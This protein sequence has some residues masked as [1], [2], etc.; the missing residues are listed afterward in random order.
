MS[1]YKNKEDRKEQPG[2]F[3]KVITW[4]HSSACKS[5]C[6]LLVGFILAFLLYCVFCAP[7]QYDLSVGSIA[8]ETISATKDVVDEVTTEERRQT[9]AAAVEPSYRFQEGIKEEV[10]SSLKDVFNELRTVQQYAMTLH[11]DQNESLTSFSDTE[12]DYAL[13]L[14]TSISLTRYQIT[15]L[16]NTDSEEFEEMVSLVSTAVENSLNNLIREGQLNQSI[17]TILQIVG[18]RLD[19]SLTQNIVPSVLRACL[20]PNMIIEQETTEI[21]REAARSSVEPVIYLQ[22]QNIVREGERVTKSQLEMLHS[23]G[24]LKDNTYD[25]SSYYGAFLIVLLAMLVFVF[26][27]HLQNRSILLNPRKIS[28]A[29]IVLLIGLGFSV[30]IHQFFNAYLTPAAFVPLLLTVLLGSEVGYASV[31]TNAV[32]LSGLA[33]TTNNTY[34]YEMILLLL[35]SLIGGVT[36]VHFLKGFA[37]RIRVL[38]VS[39]L[40]AMINAVVVF[41]VSQ[42]TSSDTFNPLDHVLWSIGGG[43]LSGILAISFQPIFETLF[44]LATP[45][46]LQELCN[47]NQSLLRR[48]LLEAPGTYH[49]SIIVANLA[50]AAAERIGANP[51]L[52]RAAAHYHDIGKLKRPMFFKENQQ[53]E[54]PHDKIDPYIS[55]A[56]LTSHTRYGY[57]MAMKEHMPQ[58]MMDIILQHHGDTPVMFFY[59]KALQLSNGTPVDINEFR[60]EGPRPQTRE[61]AIVMLADTIEAAVRSMPDP[62]PK[63]INQFIER[64]V[65]GKLEDGQLSEAPITLRDIDEICDAFSAVLMGVFH[66]R[67]EYPEVLHRVPASAPHPVSVQTAV[68]SNIPAV[69]TTSEI[70]EPESKKESTEKDNIS[71]KISEQSPPKADRSNSNDTDNA[72]D[73]REG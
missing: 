45:S 6:I 47:P 35:M 7:Q 14:V 31:I 8:H 71:E 49:H 1:V 12:I 24:L 19:V 10:L 22:G 64:L 21:A 54:N 27:I 38:L 58:E 13:K 32:L 40:A 73:S 37:A 26:S 11:E 69:S 3:K 18:Y 25:L 33:A 20:K 65:R 44:R 72:I 61:A 46:R 59:H 55:A 4:F 62:T 28:V 56:I 23:L 36:S 9:A 42:M 16:L 68:P 5:A 53:V 39:L 15:T 67:I 30:I 70:Q 57:Q 50:E 17:Q 51:Y 66:E 60:Y 34:L 52:A 29:M 41:A 48:M 63:T 43:L 2:L